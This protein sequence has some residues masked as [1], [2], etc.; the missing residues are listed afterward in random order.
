MLYYCVSTINNYTNWQSIYTWQQNSEMENLQLV[1]INL[2]N[3]YTV[4]NMF[5]CIVFSFHFSLCIL[6]YSSKQ[7]TIAILIE[8]DKHFMDSI[9]EFTFSKCSQILYFC[10]E[11]HNIIKGIPNLIIVWPMFS[12]NVFEILSLEHTVHHKILKLH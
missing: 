1:M 4:H 3:I 10:L 6:L 5:L 8:I 2:H 12:F 7:Y 11:I 9:K